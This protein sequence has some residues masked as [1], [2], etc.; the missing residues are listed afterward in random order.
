M[1]QVNKEILFADIK[2]SY[3]G[4]VF[5]IYGVV[6]KYNG[7]YYYNNRI[8]KEFKINDKVKV[9]EVVKIK[10]LGYETKSKKYHE[11][12]KSTEKRNKITGAYE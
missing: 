8:L 5:W 11:V 12:K 7:G 6:Y 9:L 3:K 4:K 1:E 2:V 10:S